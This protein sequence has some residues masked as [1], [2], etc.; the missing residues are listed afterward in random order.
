MGSRGQPEKKGEGIGSLTK[1]LT[2]KK[3]GQKSNYFSGIECPVNKGSTAEGWKKKRTT[4]TLYFGRTERGVLLIQVL[5]ATKNEK[6]YGRPGG[7]RG[8]IL[9]TEDDQNNFYPRVLRGNRD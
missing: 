9:G 2:K 6:K 3:S 7:R 5:D 1:D 8:Q 4:S